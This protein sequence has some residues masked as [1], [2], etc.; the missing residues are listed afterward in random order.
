MTEAVFKS[1]FHDYY[2]VL[3]NYAYKYVK[4][5]KVA[6]DVVQDTF[7][8]YWEQK[9]EYSEPELRYLLFKMV[10]NR[11]IDIWRKNNK[12]QEY[13]EEAFLKSNVHEESDNYILKERIF[14]S[15]R[16]LPPKCQ[17]VFTLSKVNGLTYTEI[18]ESLGISIKTVENH[19]GK[20]LKILRDQ[21]RDLS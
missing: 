14:K 15:I 1:I 6:E 13:Q 5:H 10:K 9:S 16:H 21:L 12:F 8:K 11:S 17:E 20:A 19:M 3:V 18:A 7:L 2:N 4:D